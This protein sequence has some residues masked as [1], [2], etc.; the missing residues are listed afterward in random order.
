[1]M[2]ETYR[3]ELDWNFK[4]GIFHDPEKEVKLCKR[5]K[6]LYTF[7]LE[8]INEFGQHTSDGG[9]RILRQRG[10]DDSEK[11]PS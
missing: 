11:D 1:M 5:P 9:H 6:K 2:I 10:E 4:D 8:F 7:P 3:K